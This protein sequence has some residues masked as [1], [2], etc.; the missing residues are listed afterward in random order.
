M[1][2]SES[3]PIGDLKSAAAA[4]AVEIAGVV[5][6]S[7][8][9]PLPETLRQRFIAVRTELFKRGLFDPTLAR[10]DSATVAQPTLREIAEELARVAEAV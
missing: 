6:D 4:V 9:A 1:Q 7:P 3:Q 8:S 2:S 5:A 10:F